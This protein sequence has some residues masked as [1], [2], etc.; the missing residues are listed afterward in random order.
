M[1]A[2]GNQGGVRSFR[3]PPKG[4]RVKTA[5]DQTR[6]S[7][8]MIPPIPTCCACGGDGLGNGGSRGEG[9]AAVS[10]GRRWAGGVVSSELSGIIG[11]DKITRRL[12]RGRRIFTKWNGV[13]GYLVRL[14]LY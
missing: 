1:V 4:L 12:C 10:T 13:P 11:Y 5:G 3:S 8:G 6:N 2:A 14:T 7:Y 9:S